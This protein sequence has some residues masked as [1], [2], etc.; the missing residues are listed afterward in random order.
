MIERDASNLHYDFRLQL[1]DL[2][3]CWAIPAQPSPTPGDKR[4]AIRTDAASEPRPTPA[5]VW[6]SGEVRNLGDRPWEPALAEGRLHLAL[7]GD[8]LCGEFALVRTHHN[9]VQEQWL[10]ITQGGTEGSTGTGSTA[11]SV[12]TPGT[13]YDEPW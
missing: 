12:A 1:D 10:L 2:T 13:P 7:G 3:V 9:A 6:D 8:R 4:L 11:E 5:F